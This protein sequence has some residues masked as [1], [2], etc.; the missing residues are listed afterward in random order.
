MVSLAPEDIGRDG[1]WWGEG[2]LEGFQSR[3]DH[4]TNSRFQ[5][6]GGS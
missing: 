1:G 3:V 6:P 5:D 4:W 2:V